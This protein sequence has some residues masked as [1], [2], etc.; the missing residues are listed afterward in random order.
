MLKRMLQ[1]T[2]LLLITSLAIAVLA[3]LAAAEL[4]IERIMG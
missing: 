2:G 1:F 3:P 4:L